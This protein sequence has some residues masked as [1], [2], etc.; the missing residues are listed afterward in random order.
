MRLGSFN[1]DW[2]SGG[3]FDLDG[4]TMFGV[5]PKVLWRK[6]FEPFDDNYIRFLSSP[7]LVRTGSANIIIDTG[8]GNKLTGKQKSIF[9]VSQDWDLPRSLHALGLGR[10]DVDFVILTHCDFDHAGG[11]VMDVGEGELELTFPSAEHIVQ[12]MEWE[13]AM[14][15]NSR[16]A[17]T[18]LDINLALLRDSGLLRLVDGGHEVAG[19]VVLECTGG[20]TRGHQV[21]HMAS[22]GQ[23]AMHMADLMPTHAHFN[24]LWLMAYDNYPLEAIEQKRRLTY[25]AV[26]DGVWFT[27]YHDTKY[28]ACRFDTS[29]MVMEGVAPDEQGDQN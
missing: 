25:A 5:V 12:R 6:R 22:E 1:I 18:Y 2:L 14:N 7:M 8:L 11:V 29:G 28:L 26:D 24:P 17:N 21:V 16:S 19:G 20:H 4:G 3:V 9:R 10:D 13:D 23:R 15:P 27:F